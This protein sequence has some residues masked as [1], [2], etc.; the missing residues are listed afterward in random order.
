MSL[1]PD[2]RELGHELLHTRNYEIRAYRLS[3]DEMLVRGAISDV[4]PPGL[5]VADDPAP[6]ELHQM[7]VEWTVRL[8]TLEITAAEVG[9]VAHPHE[10]C[11]GIAAQYRKLVGLCIARGFT[12]KVRELFGGPRGC[13][14]TTALLQAMAPAVIQATW[15]MVILESRDS[16]EPTGGFDA[17]NESHRARLRSNI[18]S[19]HVWDEEG[20]Y[21]A[22]ALVGTDPGPPLPLKERLVELGRDPEEWSI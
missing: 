22:A 15:S 17:D 21:A 10:T 8:S 5:F 14:H 16:A 20:E 1:L 6:V 12:H 13:T 2:D 18:N 3:D 19:C 11:P 7:Q 4:K 9:F